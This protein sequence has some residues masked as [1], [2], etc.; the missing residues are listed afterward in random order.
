MITIQRCILLMPF[1]L[2]FSCGQKD[3]TEPLLKAAQLYIIDSVR[4]SEGNQFFAKPSQVDLIGD[5]ILAVSSFLTPGIWFIDVNSGEIKHR[6]VNGEILDIAI[7][8]AAFDISEYPVVHILQ[9]RLKSIISFDVE[10]AEFLKN[11]KLNFPE[12]KQVRTIES[13]FRKS[14]S[15]YL[16]E[17][18]PSNPT[19]SNYY[20]SNNGLIGIF[21]SN[22]EFQ[23][24]FLNFPEQL[25]TLKSPIMPY[26]TFAQ[27]YFP[28]KSLVAFPSSGIISQ[29]D[30]KHFPKSYLRIPL[31]SQY[32]IFDPQAILRPFDSNFDKHLDFP[33][34][35]FFFQNCGRKRKSLYPIRYEG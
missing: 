35:H 22:G 8:P 13:F 17:L 11:I 14:G 15:D 26:R 28:S 23:G 24:E 34:S 27:S 29:I 1:L 32:F 33:S 3:S 7:F 10:K 18:Y 6:I 25:S 30:A 9:P 4:V 2:L 12:G 16:V 21:D 31:N 20:S 5:S 19:S